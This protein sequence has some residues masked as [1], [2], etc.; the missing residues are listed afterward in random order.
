[1][2]NIQTEGDEIKVTAEGTTPEVF[3]ELGLVI[4]H[5]YK[6]SVSNLIEAKPSAP[7][8]IQDFVR[9]QLLRTVASAIATADMELTESGTTT[10]SDFEAIFKAMFDDKEKK[11]DSKT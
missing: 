6:T 10:N 5:I 7:T 4:H 1:M 11:D 8:M 9:N 2:L 3:N